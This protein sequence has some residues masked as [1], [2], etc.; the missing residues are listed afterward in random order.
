M[1]DRISDL[2]VQGWEKIKVQCAGYKH[3]IL[4]VYDEQ[5]FLNGYNQ[6][7]R[8]ITITGT[9]KIKPAVIITNDFE[10]KVENIVRKY[11]RRW[12]VEK[13]ISEQIDFFHLN[14]VS[15]SM[16]IKVDFDLTMSILSYNLYRL[17]ALELERYSNLSIQRLYDKFVLNGADIII[18]ENTIT[19]QLK[20]KRNLPLILEVMQQY[21]RQK[22]PWLNNMNVIFEGATYS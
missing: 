12:L 17:L 6:N 21:S 10:L 5:V 18:K 14:M 15:S 16:V 9:G 7:I 4:H 1:I 8:Q 3:R 22:Y 2:S 11:A 19:V 13:T 20:K